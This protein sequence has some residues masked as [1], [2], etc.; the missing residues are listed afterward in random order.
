VHACF[1]GLHYILCNLKKQV[2]AG[3]EKGKVGKVT[4]L[5]Q[6]NNTV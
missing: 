2:I 1:E 6:N 4:R 5:F 3:H